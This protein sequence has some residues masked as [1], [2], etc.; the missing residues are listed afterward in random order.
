MRNALRVAAAALLGVLAVVVVLLAIAPELFVLPS[1]GPDDPQ[2][3]ALRDDRGRFQDLLE[4]SSDHWFGTDE[5]GCDLYARVVFGARPSIVVGVGGAFVAV[6]IGALLGGVAGYR[7]GRLDAIVSRVVDVGL[8]I[9]ALL[10]AMVLL[11]AGGRDRS[12]FTLVLVLGLLLAPGAAR[13]ARASARQVRIEGWVVAA[14]ALGARPDRV[15]A[16]HVLPFVATPLIAFAASLVGVLIAAE[17]TLSFLGLGL[18]SPDVSWGLLVAAAEPRADVA[19]HLVIF[20][21]MFLAF[22]V[23]VFLLLG[24]IAQRR[25]TRPQP[26]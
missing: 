17:G 19:P 13:I 20:P 11:A 14:R 7:G 16:I 2:A 6:A 8:G 12:L 4:P 18:Q 26:V 15:F 10:V 24:S 22:A 3:C 5:Q 21:V 1:P 9:P 23:G 25:V